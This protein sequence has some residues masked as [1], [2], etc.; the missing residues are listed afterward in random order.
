MFVWPMSGMALLT[1]TFCFP[2]LGSRDL[3]GVPCANALIYYDS[4]GI[5]T[6]FE[7]LGLLKFLG[8]LFYF[9]P[10]ASF[11]PAG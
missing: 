9:K 5:P 3:R 10:Y 6:K 2:I 7:N 8:D 1:A 4:G 11:A